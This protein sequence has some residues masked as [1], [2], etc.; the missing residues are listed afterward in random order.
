[1]TKR[2]SSAALFALGLML[3]AC[4]SGRIE[5]P[6]LTPRPEDVVSERW[7]ELPPA[8]FREVTTDI[9][10]EAVRMLATDAVQ[11]LPGR[12]VHRF[13]PAGFA[14]QPSGRF[15]L[16]RGVRTAGQTGGYQVLVRGRA[17]TVRYSA[18]AGGGETI[19]S[20]VVA[21]LE[22]APERVYVEVSVAR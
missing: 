9:R 2:P 14:D 20:A 5:N 7:Q 22:Q 18:L 3:V 10:A 17:V 1:V 21:D 11:R 15:Y 4:S 12:E 16:L 6:W 19:Q 13:V 8:R